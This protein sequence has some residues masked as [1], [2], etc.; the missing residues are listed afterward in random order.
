MKI[1]VNAIRLSPIAILPVGLLLI[2]QAAYG[3]TC[4]WN[5]VWK[6]DFN[7]TT[8]DR[9]YWSQEVNG[10]GGGNGELQYYTDRPENMWVSGGMLNIKAIREAYNG[11]SWTSARLRTKNAQDWTYGKIE[12]RMRVPKASGTWPAFW[13]MS[14]ESQ[15]DSHGWPNNG[16]IDIMEA[17][18][19]HE[20]ISGTLHYGAYWP[21]NG[22][23]GWPNPDNLIVPE[24]GRTKT[25]FHTYAVEWYEDRM[26]W[27]IDGV[28]KISSSRT[29]LDGVNP[30]RSNWDSFYNRP[31][32]VILNLAIGGWFP[33]FPDGS[34]GPEQ[35]M[36]IDYVAVYKND[37]SWSVEGDTYVYRGENFK[38]YR[39]DGPTTASYN[40]SVP[41]GVTIVSGQGTREIVASIGNSARSGNISATFNSGCSVKTVSKP[42]TIEQGRT[43]TLTA[44]ESGLGLTH[45]QNGVALTTGAIVN[46]PAPGAVNT[47]SKV[48]HYVRD[49]SQQWDNLKLTGF[50]KLNAGELRSGRAKIFADIYYPASATNLLGKEIGGGLENNAVVSVTPSWDGNTGRLARFKGTIGKAGEWHTVELGF[51]GTPD[52]GIAASQ[53]DNLVLMVEAGFNR[54]ANF[55]MDNIRIVWPD[56]GYTVKQTIANFDG[57]SNGA[58]KA[59]P[60]TSGVRTIVANPAPNAVNSSPNVLRYVRDVGATYDTLA[61]NGITGIPD[62]MDAQHGMVRVAVDVYTTAPVGTIISMNLEN[63]LQVSAV[64]P[65]DWQVGR[66]SFYQTETTKT[67]QWETLEFNYNFAAALGDWAN[68]KASAPFTGVDQLIF[69]IT[70][71]V[72]STGTFYFDNFRVMAY[73]KDAP[74]SVGTSSS[75]TSSS[76]IAPPSSVGSSS[77]SSVAPS[78]VAPSSVASSSIPLSSSRSSVAPSSVAPSSIAS[79]SS[80]GCTVNCVPVLVSQGRTVTA[81][82][83][84]TAAAN[85][86]DGD[87]G[88]RW[89]SAHAVD[90][91]W[92]MVDLGSLKALSQVV[93]DW[94]AANAANYQVQGSTNGTSWINLKTV[95]DGTFG[96]RTDT[97]AVTGNYRY[98][99]IYATARSTGNQWGYSIWELKV[100]AQNAVAS[101]S[102]ASSSLAPAAPLNIASATASTA[103]TPAANAIDK[104]SGTRWE[105]AHALDPSSLTLDLGSAK[106]LSSIAIDWEAANAANYTV[107]GS[108]DNAN[109]TNLATR[110]GGTFGNRTDTLTIAGSY[111]YVRI[112]GTAR[113]VGNQ[114]GYS[115]WEV[116]VLGW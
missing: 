4:G 91:S 96:T 89:E 106:T 50:G 43:Q 56:N 9:N 78:S 68:N 114:W 72:A 38:K 1:I 15:R 107:Q 111:R 95:T 14:T 53:A 109:W 44:Y 108:N 49:A 62:A 88:T 3:Q 29:K 18:G 73:N 99:R 75:T 66:H 16:E 83:A 57:T 33:G 90:P 31:F 34:E 41:A 113:S 48:L 51:T 71:G 55:Y 8:V 35:L 104:N 28:P 52:S 80:V 10:D 115:I 47:S 58:I 110:T 20:D 63:E 76:S 23:T 116:R 100:Y 21:Y 94:E 17:A 25:D 60:A 11:K 61:F 112:N 81:S 19:T 6:D 98:V 39:I 46:N 5:E 64:T 12:A 102:A 97:N 32:H 59:A 42:V 86:V 67:G 87:G 69:L 30:V 27:S 7:G 65:A 40:W 85:A 93:I 77:R 45:L 70:P 24:A 79:S 101:S 84:L 26:V 54:P 82:T 37:D 36:Q 92:I 13:M 105:S 74:A 22:N 2:G 103:L